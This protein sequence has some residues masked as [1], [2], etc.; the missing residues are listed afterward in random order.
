MTEKNNHE[1]TAKYLPNYVDVEHIKL[2]FQS[3][4]V[5]VG[6]KNIMPGGNEESNLFLHSESS[7]VSANGTFKYTNLVVHDFAAYGSVL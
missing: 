6:G 7:T 1:K 3:P 4:P 2:V 5:A